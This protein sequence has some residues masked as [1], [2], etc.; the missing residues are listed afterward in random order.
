MSK[1]TKASPSRR[2]NV[3]GWPLRWER[4]WDEN[5]NTTLEAVGGSTDGESADLYYRLKQ[6]VRNDMHVWVE[7][8]S[9]ELMMD[10]EG[11][12]TWC[13]KGDAMKRMQEYHDE[14]MR[15]CRPAQ[16]TRASS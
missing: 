13:K 3:R 8:S 14:G 10:I 7:A 2:A 12:L 5:D 6:E 9:P 4:D 15:D 11:P 1:K 16:P